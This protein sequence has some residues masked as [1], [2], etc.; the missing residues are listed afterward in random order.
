MICFFY[1]HQISVF[2]GW[3]H[4]ISS[5]ANNKVCLSGNI[6]QRYA[7]HIRRDIV[8]QEFSIASG[9]K[10]IVNTNYRGRKNKSRLP[11]EKLAEVAVLEYTDDFQS[12]S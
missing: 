6:I 9:G 1:I 4:R 11:K 5:N 7:Y 3:L 2:K 10:S 12:C 8:K